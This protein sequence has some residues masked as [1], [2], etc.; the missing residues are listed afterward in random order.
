MLAH[1]DVADA[2]VIGIPDTLAGELPHAWVVRKPG[3]SVTEEDICNFM[4]GEYH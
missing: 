3:S 2:G 1:P 4:A